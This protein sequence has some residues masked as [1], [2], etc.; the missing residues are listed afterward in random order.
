MQVLKGFIEDV[1]MRQ[2]SLVVRWILFIKS[3]SLYKGIVIAN[4]YNDFH[5][6]CW[7]IEISLA[8][9]YI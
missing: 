2:V 9:V 6:C 7:L 4:F 8:K 5:Y 3:N 1:L